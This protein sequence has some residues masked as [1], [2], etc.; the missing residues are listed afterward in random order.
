MEAT[1]RK[2]RRNEDAAGEGAPRRRGV[3]RSIIVDGLGGPRSGLSYAS[4]FLMYIWARHVLEHLLG[5]PSRN[6]ALFS[7]GFSTGWM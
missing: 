2:A 5:L 1:E 3:R 6:P 4:F 7:T